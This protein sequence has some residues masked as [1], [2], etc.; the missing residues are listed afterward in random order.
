[1][2][3]STLD[4]TKTLVGIPSVFP[5]ES[6]VA[7]YISSYL[8]KLG[9]EVH[10]ISDSSRY[11]IVA[12]VNGGSD[13]AFYGH[14]D[15]VPPASDY[16]RDP[17]KLD[18]KG[19]IIRGLGVCDMKGGL[20]TMLAVG[21]FASHKNLPLTLL[22]GVDEEN[23][24][25]GAHQLVDSG[26]L[27]SLKFLIVPESGQVVDYTKPISV[28]YGRKGRFVG[29]VKVLG[30]KVHAAES[31]KG[32]NAIVR[33]SELISLINNLDLPSHNK[34]GKTS[35]VIQEIHSDTDSFSVPETCL[36][37]FSVLTT[38][39]V[40]SED[41]LYLIKD[42]AT[43]NNIYIEANIVARE[44]PYGE[45]YEIDQSNSFLKLVEKNI[46]SPLEVNPSFTPSVADEN[47]FAHR[48]KIPVLSMGLTGGGDHTKDEWTM[49]SSIE[50]LTRSFCNIVELWNS[51]R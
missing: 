20:A 24:S 47:V 7:D 17:Y 13:L 44:T 51:Q 25:L 30:K 33:A 34:L 29:E 23:I 15:T 32:I 8:T 43:K 19:D 48:L 40:E 26:L 27:N 31:E 28:N 39:G 10:K 5:N 46:F 38:P 35:I 2:K 50:V 42:I 3:N 37:R 21:D 41:I 12:F 6:K 14:M 11:N 1:M 49:I 45:A 22:F 4:L 18:I 9:F 16:D 36:V